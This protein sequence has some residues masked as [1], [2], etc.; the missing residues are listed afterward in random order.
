M[1]DVSRE[2]TLTGSALRLCRTTDTSSVKHFPAMS[3]ALLLLFCVA[4]ASSAQNDGIASGI[5]LL[6]TSVLSSVLS[7]ATGDYVDLQVYP[8]VLTPFISF[9]ESNPSALSTSDAVSAKCNLQETL[10][11]HSFAN[12]YYVPFVGSYTPPSCSFNRVVFNMTTVV[13]GVQ[14][15]RLGS[16]YLGSNEI[17][18]TTT[19][20][21]AGDP[22]TT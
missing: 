8:P 5:K 3:F 13:D 16:V 20:E 18:R 6:P 4:G 14:F 1:R 21:P 10:M 15:D 22:P 2:V 11:I 19:G 7:S 17:W 9:A 12:S